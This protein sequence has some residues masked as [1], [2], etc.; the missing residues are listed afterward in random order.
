MEPTKPKLPI[1][2]LQLYNRFIHGEMSRDPV[3]VVGAGINAWSQVPRHTIP[4]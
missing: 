2:A 3:K 1:E 4:R